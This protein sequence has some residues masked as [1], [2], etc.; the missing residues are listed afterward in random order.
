MIWLPGASLPPLP[1]STQHS[2]Q[3]GIKAA[4]LLTPI[5][6][7]KLYGIDWKR[8]CLSWPRDTTLQGK[9]RNKVSVAAS[10]SFPF[11]SFKN[12]D[13]INTSLCS[14]VRHGVPLNHGAGFKFI[15]ASPWDLFFADR[16]MYLISNTCKKRDLGVYS[17]GCHVQRR[18]RDAHAS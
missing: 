8:M 3:V 4:C 11:P 16:H 2:N 9:I 7:Q 1:S 15:S 12:T 10:S 18:D 13:A 6:M 17:S 5:T 14:G